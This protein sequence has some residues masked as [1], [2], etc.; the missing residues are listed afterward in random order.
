MQ[1]R[2]SVPFHLTSFKWNKTI[3]RVGNADLAG[4]L[5]VVFK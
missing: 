3:R 5:E 2:E 1:E 4:K